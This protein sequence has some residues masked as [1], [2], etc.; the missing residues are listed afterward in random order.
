[1]GTSWTAP[2]D[3]AAESPANAAVSSVAPA[4]TRP[5]LPKPI[6]RPSSTRPL[7][8]RGRLASADPHTG[9][10]TRAGREVAPVSGGTRLVARALVNK[11]V[12]LGE[13][14][15]SAEPIVVYDEVVARFRDDAY[16]PARP[17]RPG[18]VQQ[19]GQAAGGRGA[20]FLRVRRLWS[21]GATAGRRTCPN[22]DRSVGSPRRLNTNPSGR[23]G[24]AAKCSAGRPRRPWGPGQSDAGLPRARN[25]RSSGPGRG[26]CGLG[27]GMAPFG[28]VPAR[29]SPSLLGRPPVN[30]RHRGFLMCG[31]LSCDASATLSL[32]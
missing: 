11:G 16:P 31:L 15:Q 10:T 18:A 24:N 23:A 4:A 21:R 5:L 13:Q 9:Q 8:Y 26:R 25:G 6:L 17:G 22:T 30:H 12:G 29:P 28:K 20:R 1:V 2:Y 7:P 32:R 27:R 3:A 19:G 14:G